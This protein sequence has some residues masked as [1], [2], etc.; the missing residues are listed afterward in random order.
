MRNTP[1]TFARRISLSPVTLCVFVTPSLAYT[2]SRTSPS[3]NRF[4]LPSVSRGVATR[5]ILEETSMFQAYHGVSSAEH[6][7][8]F[9]ALS[10]QGYRMISLSVYGDP[11]SAQ[12][13]A[14]W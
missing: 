2:E 12:Y 4:C 7:A 1:S 11:G 8:K 5:G 14:V 3:N 13:A 9:N 6:Q 10:Q